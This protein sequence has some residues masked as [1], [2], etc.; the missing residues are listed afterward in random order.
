MTPSIGLITLQRLKFSSA[1][2]NS[3]PFVE[4]VDDAGSS[5]EGNRLAASVAFT[6]VDAV[7]MVY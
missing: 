3:A 4:T 6:A 1:S 7:A 5:L 2:I